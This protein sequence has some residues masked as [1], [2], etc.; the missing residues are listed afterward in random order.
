MTRGSLNSFVTSAGR[1]CTSCDSGRMMTGAELSSLATALDE[2][3]Q[4]ITA[5]ADDAA[6]QQR[7]DVAS[8]LFEVERALT[9]ASRRLMKVVETSA[10]SR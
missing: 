1:L 4:R 6:S 10:R 2:L 3:T 9:G 7:D 5:M 8:E